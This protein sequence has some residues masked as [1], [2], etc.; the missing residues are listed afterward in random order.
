VRLP[1]APASSSA[2]A[3]IRELAAQLAPAGAAHAG[4]AR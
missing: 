2:A 4:A 1:L 3:R